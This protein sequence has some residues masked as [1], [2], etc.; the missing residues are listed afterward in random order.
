MAYLPHFEAR[1]W[2]SFHTS[3][4]E[5]SSNTDSLSIRL[6]GCHFLRSPHQCRPQVTRSVPRREK[7]TSLVFLLSVAQ[8][9]NPGKGK[10]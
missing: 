6:F 8:G 9:H 1:S 4:T 2:P 3:Q 10:I 5:L 7:L